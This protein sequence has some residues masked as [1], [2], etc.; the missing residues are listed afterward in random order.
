MPIPGRE[1]V[2]P[3]ISRL[4]YIYIDPIV[5]LAN[6]VSHLS[7]DQLPP[8]LD[9]DDASYL[10][11]QASQVCIYLSS[12]YLLLIVGSISA[13]IRSLVLNNVIYSGDC[14]TTSV[15]PHSSLPFRIV[16]TI[17]LPGWEF[18]VGGI[19]LLGAAIS[20]FA[21]PVSINMILT[22]VHVCFL[23][24]QLLQFSF[25]KAIWKLMER[26]R[27]PNLGFGWSFFLLAHF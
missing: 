19:C 16:L 10:T 8:L 5:V 2:D 9:V 26:M 15:R 21:G 3:W 12:T 7:F 24:T 18:F 17:S 22:Y 4:T 27:L 13:S 23:E 20:T 11:K 6:K 14:W 25:F 1:L